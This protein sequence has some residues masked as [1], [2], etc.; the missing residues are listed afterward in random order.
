MDDTISQSLFP[1]NLLE[2]REEKKQEGTT[3]WTREERKHLQSLIKIHGA[4]DWSSIA[5]LLNEK[6][7]ESS[8]TPSQCRCLWQRY[9]RSAHSLARNHWTEKEEAELLFAHSKHKN[10]WAN[11][12]NALHGKS[13]NSIK[14][15]FYTIFRKV[16]NKVKKADFSFT[17]K[18]E[19]LQIHYMI[20][21]MEAYASTIKSAEGSNEMAGKDFVYKLMLQ[22][23]SK[24]L[25]N[26]S[27]KF[28]QITKA[29]GTMQTLF[30]EILNLNNPA[31][32]IANTISEPQPT[33]TQEVCNPI[34]IESMEEGNGA[35]VK[36]KLPLIVADNQTPFSPT[37]VT[38]CN[39]SVSFFLTKYSPCILS[40]GPAAAAAAA[41]EAPCFQA[42]PDNLGFS[43]FTE[44]G[45][46][47]KRKT[48]ISNDLLSPL[49]LKE[50]TGKTWSQHNE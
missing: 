33:D 37:D 11:I 10:S 48:Q 42:D 50:S 46:F 16:K 7:P 14:N 39:P 30:H 25:D 43:E 1:N 29:Y 27:T 36:D 12:S 21:V 5:K 9:T 13:N 41:P 8:H 31:E 38:L 4:K 35:T 20:S 19:V 2:Q 45:L 40:A 44:G 49:V 26:Y 23:N 24:S 3:K 28:R 34:S 6:F 47:D 15:R 32:P 18:Y 17:S 22:I